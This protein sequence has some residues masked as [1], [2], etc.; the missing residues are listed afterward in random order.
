[1]I[2]MFKNNKQATIYIALLLLLSS[3]GAKKKLPSTKFEVKNENINF[4][5]EKTI[6]KKI[7]KT[8]WHNDYLRSTHIMYYGYNSTQNNDIRNFDQQQNI[9]INTKTKLG[10][11][12]YFKKDKFELTDE[13]KIQ[14]RNIF[15]PFFDSLLHSSAPKIYINLY[16]IGFTNMGKIDSTSEIYY[17][18]K[19][20]VGIPT[21]TPEK[22][23]ACISYLRAKALS[24]ILVTMLE[25]RAYLF[26]N[27]QKVQCN[28]I[29]QGNVVEPYNA[30][31]KMTEDKT[32]ATKVFYSLENY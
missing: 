22:Y 10:K 32:R 9:D 20:Q 25:E 16:V 6:Q 24:D 19:N 31:A 14:A 12:L 29:T 18:V 23:N 27:Y 17:T 11:T 21:I 15:I 28:I 7:Y 4:K 3:C 2:N 1:M 5:L 30:K 13:I 8:A 26:S